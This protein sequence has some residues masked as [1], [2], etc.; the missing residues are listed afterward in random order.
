MRGRMADRA[1]YTPSSRQGKRCPGARSGDR[2]VQLDHVRLAPELQVG[3]RCRAARSASCGFRRSS[4][5]A[6]DLVSSWFGLARRFNAPAGSLQKLDTF[7]LPPQ[8]FLGV[9]AS[10][11]DGLG[12]LAQ[13]R[14]ALNPVTWC[15]VS[16]ASGAVGSVVCQIAK[17]KG[18][19]HRVGRRSGQMCL[20]QGHRADHVIDYKARAI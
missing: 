9:A 2:R 14:N 5:Q 18:T 10:R 7:G 4:I 19:R 1:I 13:D 20:C 12:G 8:V 3:E 16:A 17:L 6:G 11:A 15:F